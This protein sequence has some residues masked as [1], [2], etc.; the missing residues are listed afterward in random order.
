[1]KK[2][3]FIIFLLF[4]GIGFAQAQATASDG[5]PVVKKYN[6]KVT[7][8]QEDLQKLFIQGFNG[9]EYYLLDSAVV[10]KGTAVF[11]KSKCEVPCGV[12]L[13]AYFDSTHSYTNIIGEFI[14]NQEAKFV[15]H[16]SQHLDSTIGYIIDD[17]NIEGS[18]ENALLY[19][20]RDR[21]MT[22]FTPDIRPICKEYRDMSPEGFVGKYVTAAYGTLQMANRTKDE[23]HAKIMQMIDDMDFSEPRLLHSPLIIFNALD[24]WVKR[25]DDADT[26]MASMDYILKRCTNPIVRNFFLNHFFTMAD[27]HD[28]VLDPILVYLYDNYDHDWIPEGREGS[29]KRKIESLRKVISGARIP[30]LISHDLDG[31]PHSTNDIKTKY[32]VLWFWDPDCDHCQE[33]TPQLHQMYVD[34]AEEYD[35]EV[36]AVEVNDDYERWKKFSDEHNLWDWINL[37]TSRGEQNIDFIEYFDI[38]TTPVI[39]LIDNSMYHTIIARQITLSELQKFFE[40]N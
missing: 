35:F 21:L 5:T 14:I 9:S 31:D 11:K 7:T 3:P 33:M 2:I 30:E 23:A 27:I 24:H 39:L 22:V 40:N 37:S 18:P 17:I 38:V 13:L 1:M 15:I 29:T 12:Y 32:T 25:E 36:F 26:I 20:F 6:I 16:H 4:F 28:P 19:S 10:K 34:H 8:T